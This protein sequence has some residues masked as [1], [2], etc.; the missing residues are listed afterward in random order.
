[1]NLSKE[2]KLISRIVE[3]IEQLSPEARQWLRKRLLADVVD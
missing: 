3:L 1:M 2:I